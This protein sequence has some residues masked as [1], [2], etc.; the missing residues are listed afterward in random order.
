MG[1]KLTT[2]ALDQLFISD[3]IDVIHV[4]MTVLI[5]SLA[6]LFFS[7]LKI[8]YHQG[9]LVQL[10]KFALNLFQTLPLNFRR[11]SGQ[12]STLYLF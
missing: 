8:T 7:L 1:I 6:P 9:N 4:S 11:L 12:E 3:L 2:A 5:S 10:T